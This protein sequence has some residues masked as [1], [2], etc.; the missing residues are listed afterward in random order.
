MDKGVIVYCLFPLTTKGD[1]QT[2]Q[3]SDPQYQC[4]PPRCSDCISL[5]EGKSLQAMNRNKEF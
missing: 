3:Q 1:C 2:V 5:K 4:D